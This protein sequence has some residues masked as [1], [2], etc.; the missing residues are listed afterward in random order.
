[1]KLILPVLFTFFLSSSFSTSAQSSNALFLGADYSWNDQLS[2]L[3]V[4]MDF[5]QFFD[6]SR[7][8]INIGLSG[9][10]GFGTYQNDLSNGIVMSN[11]YNQ[12]SGDIYVNHQMPEKTDGGFYLSGRALFMIAFR[13]T[14][15]KL[16]IGPRLNYFFKQELSVLIQSED[17]NY[18]YDEF[19]QIPYRDGE[20]VPGL[21]L[22]M[23]FADAVSVKY[24]RLLTPNEAVAMHAIGLTF[25]MNFLSYA[26]Y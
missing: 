24:A 21:E 20:I 1:M 13:N 8:G 12:M 19:A 10:P 15:F 3:G 23:T 26:S 11:I 18:I 4:A 6:K 22:N 17:A 25:S 5:G 9:G 14:R 2:G 7:F 16:A